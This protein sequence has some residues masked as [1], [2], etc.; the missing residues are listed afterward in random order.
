MPVAW[1]RD[2][3]DSASSAA[4]VAARPV[5]CT[6]LIRSPKTKKPM[7]APSGS[8]DCCM[9][10]ATAKPD[11]RIAMSSAAVAPTWLT[12]PTVTAIRNRDDG[13]GMASGVINATAA[14]IA[15][16]NGRPNR[17]RTSVAPQGPASPT[18]P[19]CRAL[20]ATCSGVAAA[21]RRIQSIRASFPSPSWGGWTPRS[22]GR[23]GKCGPVC[24]VRA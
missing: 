21:V 10:V 11:V 7:R 4:V 19:R 14:K 22:G 8:E 5:H 24:G 17:N 6:P 16:E 20:R 1:V 3:Q 9:K 18:R 15:R 12:A 2:G 23:V 13:L